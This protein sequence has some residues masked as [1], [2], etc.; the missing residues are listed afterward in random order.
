MPL[1]RLV[2]AS[3]EEHMARNRAKQ[4]VFPL[5]KRLKA[6]PEAL[7]WTAGDEQNTKHVGAQRRRTACSP[8]SFAVGTPCVPEALF[9]SVSKKTAGPGDRE[10]TLPV[11]RVSNF[12]LQDTKQQLQDH[13]WGDYFS[14][15][16]SGSAAKVT[17]ARTRPGR[18]WRPGRSGHV[19]LQL[20]CQRTW[21]EVARS[22]GIFL[23]FNS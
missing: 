11:P 17:R 5:G 4:M 3:A 9:S 18:R 10:G 20:T 22:W 15:R 14:M 21:P 1:I 13:W 19:V 23:D 16:D 12:T 2:T 7:R 6:S 8:V